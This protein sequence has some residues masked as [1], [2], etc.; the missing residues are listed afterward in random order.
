MLT[1]Y[2]RDMGKLKIR[3]VAFLF[4]LSFVTFQNNSSADVQTK[5]LTAEDYRIQAFAEQQ[6]G[7]YLEALTLYTKAEDL[8]LRN[9]LLFNDLGI[10][11]E[12]IG[13]TNKAEHYYLKATHIDASYLPAYT[14]L[15]Y[16][17]KKIGNK[18]KALRYFLLRYELSDSGDIWADKVK[19]EIITID[20]RYK[21][22]FYL[23]ELKEFE[24]ELEERSRERFEE[25]IKHSHDLFQKGQ[26][27]Y[28]QKQ[29]EQAIAVYNQALKIT[30]ENPKVIR[31][32]AQVHA[33]KETMAVELI[34]K[35]A[36][37]LL[38]A[39]DYLSARNEIQKILATK[40]YNSE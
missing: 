22:K 15:G 19:A 18:E 26:E 7:Q 20:A 38:E 1:S 33:D 2:K 32:M 3:L 11:Y 21:E 24:Q 37:E 29:Y 28:A 31:A 30:P 8:G 6:K 40:Q 25:R 35:N 23:K 4:V 16:F 12:H 39:G 34:K 14:N 36:L 13:L 17:Y 27:L 9:A 5:E 10:L